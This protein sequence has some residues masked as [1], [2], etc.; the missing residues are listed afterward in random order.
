[1]YGCDVSESEFNLFMR[2][3]R[4]ENAIMNEEINELIAVLIN[5]PISHLNCYLVLTWS[6]FVCYFGKLA[7]AWTWVRCYDIGGRYKFAI[8]LV[9]AHLHYG[10]L[11]R[12]L[13]IQEHEKLSLAK[14]IL[15]KKKFSISDFDIFMEM[16]EIFSIYFLY[17]ME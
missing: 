6:T 4:Y 3:C 15:S 9:L 14:Q 12:I 8:A 17:W 7:D 11:E 13:Q 2:H 5:C 10:R 16:N 1:M